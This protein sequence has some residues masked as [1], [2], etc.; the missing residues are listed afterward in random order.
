MHLR[1]EGLVSQAEPEAEIRTH[2]EQYLHQTPHEEDVR[3]VAAQLAAAGWPLSHDTH[4]GADAP[5]TN[6][7][8]AN[9]DVTNDD[10]TNHEATNNAATNDA[11][12]ATPADDPG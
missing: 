5:V 2:I 6:H 12:T 3:R 11:A 4:P 10:V 1:E 7:L 9:H 8:A